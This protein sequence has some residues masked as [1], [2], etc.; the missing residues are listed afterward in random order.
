M[1]IEFRCTSCGRLLRV[2]DAAAGRLAQCPQC[3]GRSSVP[4]ATDAS[5]FAPGGLG[6][7]AGADSVNPYQSP[8]QTGGPALIDA[9]LVREYA[10]ARVA[11][12]AI[13]LIVVGML[14]VL[15]HIAMAA[16]ML[17]PPMVQ[18]PHGQRAFGEFVATC[19]II[20]ILVLL[21][22][23]VIVGGI[24]MKGLQNRGLAMAAAIIAIVPCFYPCCV[25]GLPFGIWALVVLCDAN[26]RTAFDGREHVMWI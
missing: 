23:I 22:I 25:L 17:M 6:P 4:A 16:F 21:D 26:V 18:R 19:G 9:G 12:P 5:P 8:T 1:A 13:A 10:A 11:G 2:D 15:G 7:S 24:K 3:G 14:S 20:A